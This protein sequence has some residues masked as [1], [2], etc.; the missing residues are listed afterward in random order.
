[1][2]GMKKSTLCLLPHDPS[3]KKC[4]ED[5]KKRILYAVN[6][7]TIG[8]EHIGSTSIPNVLAKPILDLA[9]HVEKCE[10]SNL[11]NTLKSLGYDYRGPYGEDFGHYYAVF[12]RDEMRYCQAH[13][14]TNQTADWKCKIKFRDVLRKNDELAAEYSS[15]K[16]DLAQKVLTKGEYAAIK[17]NWLD[18]FIKKVTAVQSND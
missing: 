6:L 1:M 16:Q 11:A 9:L 3:W 13:I 10:L 18:S 4:F 2:Y 5:E 15:Y 17:S 14:Y 8:I 12:D 7:K